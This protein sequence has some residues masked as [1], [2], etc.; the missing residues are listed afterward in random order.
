METTALLGGRTE[1]ARLGLAGWWLG[2]GAGRFEEDQAVDAVQSAREAGVAFFQSSHSHDGSASERL[3]GRLLAVDLRARRESL[4]LA[5]RAG[6]G[7]QAGTPVRDASPRAIR[8]SIERSLR[9]LG[10]D[11]VDLAFLSWRDPATP[12]AATAEVTAQLVAEGKVLHVGVCEYPL[13]DVR[14]LASLAPLAAV[15]LSYNLLRG[16][17]AP[18]ELLAHCAEQ[19]LA[20][21]AYA[22]LA[23]GLLSG[24][25]DA[26][27]Q[28][29]VGDWRRALPLFGEELHERLQA[30]AALERFAAAR[31]WTLV[32]LAFAYVL[33]APGIDLALMAP[34][35]SWH[36][37]DVLSA[38][39]LRLTGEERTTVERLAGTAS[40]AGWTRS[41]WV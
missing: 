8:G 31:D 41:D 27:T 12:L 11:H 15:Q 21:I 2:G 35:Y 20:T 1:V 4:V 26:H 34:R 29:P 37:R 16:G 10:V 36:V 19:G 14:Q 3:L 32:E 6:V 39:A 22:P 24:T 30:V 5:V 18:A 33:G 38:A 17:Q 23:H 40:L 28:L 13:A 7:L 9:N 25:F